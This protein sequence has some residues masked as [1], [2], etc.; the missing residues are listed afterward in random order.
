MDVTRSD[1]VRRREALKLEIHYISSLGSLMQRCSENL[2]VILSVHIR[3]LLQAYENEY[4]NGQKAGIRLALRE[5]GAALSTALDYTKI[6]FMGFGNAN[7]SESG[8]S[9]GKSLRDDL[10]KVPK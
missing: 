7:A 1:P 4:D 6:D 10:K 2:L 3:T 5:F 8:L 9:I